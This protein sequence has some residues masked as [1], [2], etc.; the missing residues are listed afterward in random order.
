MANASAPRAWIRPLGWLKSAAR[1]VLVGVVVVVVVAP[2][3][4]SLGSSLSTASPLCVL[5]SSAWLVVP[6]GVP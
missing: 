2:A 4:V 3:G 1:L 5:L 6:H